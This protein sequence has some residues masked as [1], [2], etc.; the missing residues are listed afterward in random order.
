MT[1]LRLK[2]MKIRPK[3]AAFVVLRLLLVAKPAKMTKLRLKTTKM[4]PKGAAFVA[5]VRPPELH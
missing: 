3:R 1:K 2:T 5:L 4:C